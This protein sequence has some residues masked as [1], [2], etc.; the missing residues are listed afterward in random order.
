MNTWYKIKVST[1]KRYQKGLAEAENIN[2]VEER[3]KKLGGEIK[4][5]AKPDNGHHPHSLKDPTPIVE[6][7]T[8]AIAG[9]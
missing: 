6:F 4:I 9:K 2:I 7:I 5:I 1:I 8:K 3:Y